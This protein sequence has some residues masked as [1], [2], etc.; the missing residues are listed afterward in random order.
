MTVSLEPAEQTVNEGDE[1]VVTARLS[2]ASDEDITVTLTASGG[3]ANTDDH[4]LTMQEL[5]IEAGDLTAT[6]TISTTDDDIYESDETL[7]LRLSSSAEVERDVSVIR[8]SDNDPIP[9]LSLEQ[10]NLSVRE[11]SSVTIRA[12]LSNPSAEAILVALAFEG[13]T[14][15]LDSDYLLPAELITEIAPGTEI[16]E[17]IIRTV[18]D[19]VYEPVETAILGLRVIEGE[20][21]RG[22]SDWD[23][24]HN[25]R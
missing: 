22:H 21:H 11:G 13:E 7:V 24:V 6:F 5:T 2:E 8:I 25:R 20:C 3:T 16:A 4:G 9:T 17:F 1:I 12:R 19:S 23:A 18:D 10:D 15:L 14:A